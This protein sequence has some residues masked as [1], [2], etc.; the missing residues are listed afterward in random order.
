VKYCVLVPL[1][2]ICALAA[3]LYLLLIPLCCVWQGFYF[4]LLP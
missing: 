1:F 4:C 2:A 3:P